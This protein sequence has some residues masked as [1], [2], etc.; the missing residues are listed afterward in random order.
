MTSGQSDRGNKVECFD[1]SLRRSHKCQIICNKMKR[2]Y[3][4]LFVVYLR[5]L[6][7]SLVFVFLRLN[8]VNCTSDVA[9]ILQEDLEQVVQP[10]DR[11]GHVLFVVV[12]VGDLFQ[13]QFL[14]FD[15]V[16]E[17]IFARRGR[18]QN[19]SHVDDVFGVVDENLSPQSVLDGHR[20][21]VRELLTLLD[22]FS[23]DAV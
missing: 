23:L 11:L 6:L 15:A 19:V 20:Q 21:H 2:N 8:F 10:L 22:Q 1:S 7:E 3:F 9:V 5:R 18:V 4:I 17:D 13:R 16:A 12:D 14:E